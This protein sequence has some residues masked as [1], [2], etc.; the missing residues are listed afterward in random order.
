MSSNRKK[1]AFTLAEVMVVLLVLT[2][3]FAAFAPLVT[4][5]R[6][7]GEIKKEL[8]LWS[9]RNYMAGPMNAYYQPNTDSYMGGVYF[10]TTPDSENDIKSSY[11]PLSRVVIRSGYVFATNTIQKQL[12]L[13]F[14]REDFDDPGT[15]AGSLLADGTNLLL[16]AEYPMLLFKNKS[17][18]YPSSNLA[19][20]YGALDALKDYDNESNVA[21]NN[22]AFGYYSSS[23]LY[24]GKDNTTI[25]SGSGYVNL[26]GSNNTFVGYNA[27]YDAETFGNVLIGYE[28]SSIIGNYN[29]FIGAS[30]GKTKKEFVDEET[31]EVECDECG[32]T[33]VVKLNKDN[34]FNVAIGYRALDSIASGKRN[35]AIGSG[36]LKNLTTGSYNVAIGYNACSGFTKESYKTCIGYNSGPAYNTPVATELGFDRLDSTPRT[37][38]GS[39]PNMNTDGTW[40]GGLYGGDA[41]LELHNSPGR[42]NTKLIN[43]PGIVSNATTIINGNLVVRG[44]TYFTIGN[45]LYPFYY[46]NIGSTSVFGTNVDAPCAP[47]QITYNFTTT[48]NCAPLSYIRNATSD[49]RLKNISDKNLSGLDKIKQLKVYNYIFKNDKNKT[50]QVGVIAQELQ[51]VFPTAVFKDD[52]GYLKIRWDEMFYAV[53]NSIKELNSKV[54]NL[55]K[56]ALTLENKIQKLEKKNAELKSQVTL[57]KTRVEKLK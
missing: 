5:R 9:S 41:V 17:G 52:D 26:T 32:G 36:A 57:L 44:K 13:R 23:N 56:R 54:A 24:N 12:Q 20:G 55:T 43:N 31:E 1:P 2:I 33:K 51:K 39:N 25:G 40:K 38:I 14:G 30:T 49:R 15:F 29:T 42:G 19:F 11:T 21:K 35:V 37:Y 8:W 45:I 6:R 48:G 16:G 22:T 53:I 27:G 7:S 46:A 28:A 47:N 4:K 10:G 34:D 3:L 18:T 50:P